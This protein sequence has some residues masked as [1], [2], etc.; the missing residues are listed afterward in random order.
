MIRVL[1]A[2][3]Q[4]MVRGALRALLAM[5]EDIEVVAEAARADE[6]VAV[7]AATRPDVALLDIEMP[8]GDGISAAAALRETLPG[9]RSLIL[10]TFGRPGFLRRALETG[11]YGFLLKDAPPEE[12]A[13]AIRRTARGD[14]V[15]DPGLAVTALSD[16]VS[17]LTERE[18]Q[19]LAATDRGADLDEIA[20]T[21]FL[22]RGTVRNHLSS[23]IQKLGVK[24]RLEAARVAEAR[25]WL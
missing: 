8:G 14:R 9:C 16:G 12:L 10:T 21:L 18:R 11:A 23:A 20:R 25:G 19:V 5:E 17:P 3:D 13:H 7:A 22:S 6:V 2:E 15:V 4:A 1:I 24:N